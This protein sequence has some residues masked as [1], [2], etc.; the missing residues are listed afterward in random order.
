[1]SDTAEARYTDA[2]RQAMP[3]T[4]ACAGLDTGP[5]DVAPLISP[6]LFEVERERIFR[7]AWLKV[8]R[9]EEIPASGDYK[10]KQLDVANTAA[11]IVRGRDGEVRAF[12]NICT[13]RGNK[14][15]QETGNE[16]CGQARANTLTCRFHAWSF[17]TDGR[18]KAVAREQ[19]FHGL[20]K[21]CLGLPPIHCDT[22][23]GFIFICLADEPEWTLR[24]YLDGMAD[25]FGGF[26]YHEATAAYRYS[27]VLKCNWKVALYA[28]GEGYHV[29]TIHAATL[30]SLAKIRHT[31]FALHGVHSTSALY[32]AGLEK[33]QPTPV[34]G[35]LGGMLKGS[36]RYGPRADALPAGI[37]PE[38]SADFHFEFPVF[39]PNFIMHVCS[40]YA[41]PGMAYFTHQFWP[42]SVDECL[43]EGTNYFYAP[44]TAAERIAIAHTNA[45]HRNA[46]LEDTGTMEDTHAALKSGVLKQM[47][48][49][50]EELMVRH[51][52]QQWHRFTG[53][54]A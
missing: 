12:H 44:R 22:W 5:V 17:S 2:E 35:A 20:D 24:E 8:G 32:V 37:N 45:L 26:P 14:L 4:T 11:L 25:H 16:T 49:M 48:L 6:E 31:G 39:F 50:D 21:S 19:A 1:M 41:Y 51:A 53:V 7:R 33:A 27:T 40:G 29:P 9:V 3:Y 30:P 42:L 23:E 13:H 46:W 10:V 43:W 54:P 34:T 36:D 38:R 15:V 28:F 47:P 52:H 18:L